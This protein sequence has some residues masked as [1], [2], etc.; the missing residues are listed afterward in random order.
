MSALSGELRASQD[1]E[2]FRLG[3]HGLDCT[4]NSLP[5]KSSAVIGASAWALKAEQVDHTVQIIGRLGGLLVDLGFQVYP[6]GADATRTAL[7]SLMVSVCGDETGN[8]S[9][10]MIPPGFPP[11]PASGGGTSRDQTASL[12]SATP[13]D[14]GRHGTRRDRSAHNPKVAGSNPTLSALRGGVPVSLPMP[15]PC[16]RCVPTADL[17]AGDRVEAFVDDRVPAVAFVCDVSLHDVPSSCPED[18]DPVEGSVE[19]ALRLS[20]SQTGLPETAH[21]TGIDARIKPVEE[22]WRASRKLR[23][24]Q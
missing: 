7:P 9:A 11:S 4:A 21:S 14:A 23:P 5:T 6:V 10:S 2:R 20:V 1:A 13:G 17:P 16:A 15:C 22:L 18:R 8:D 12:E 3:L 19:E 24:I